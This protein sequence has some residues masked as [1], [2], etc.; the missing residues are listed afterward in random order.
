M[1]DKKLLNNIKSASKCMEKVFE[2]ILKVSETPSSVLIT[3]ESG[4]GKELVA[5]A[6]HEIGARK[7][8]PFVALNCG[9]VPGELM[10][11]EMFGHEKGAFTGAYTRK[12]GRFERAEGGTL[13]LDDIG[14]LQSHLQVKLLRV[15]QERSFERVGGI[16][17]IETDIRLI[18]ATNKC[19]KKAVEA[20]EFRDDLYYRL[21]VVPIDIPPLRERTE[22]IAPLIEHFL[23]CHNRKCSKDIKG[24]SPELTSELL[25]YPWPGNV[26]ELENLIERLVV[27]GASKSVISLSELPEDFCS[28]TVP[29]G[30]APEPRP[31]DLR[32]A[33][34]AFEK[35]FIIS[36]LKT[37]G[38]RRGKTARQLKIHRNTLL[39]KMK[40]Y[41]ISVPAN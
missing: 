22:D 37:C 32:R 9:A 31:T 6:I 25:S 15:L 35:S 13:F 3:G 23:Q 27:F 16:R 10:E 19:L 30:K 41:N 7:D 17:T 18:T 34:G 39:A 29:S 33:R 24:L 21:K 20:G 2:D 26:R 38:F 40:E 28:K 36:A 14:T 1:L 4:T 11:S 8:M 5:R 12:V